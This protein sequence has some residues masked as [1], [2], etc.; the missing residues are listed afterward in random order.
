MLVGAV[1]ARIAAGAWPDLDAA[2]GRHAGDPGFP[3][4][5]LAFATAIL[6]TL[7]GH[8]VRPARRLGDRLL[9]FGALAV[10]CGQTATPSAVLAAVLAGAAAAAGSRLC[11]APPP[12][13][14]ASTTS[15]RRSASSGSPPTT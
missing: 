4:A 1:A 5:R 11:S 14:R 15:R 7:N 9:V 8:L 6:L 12:A 3:E 13:A 2:L 10:A